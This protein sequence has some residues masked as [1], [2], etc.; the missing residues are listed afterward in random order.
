MEDGAETRDGLWLFAYGTL[1]QD[2]VQQALFGRL[3]R[4]E[5]D[6]LPGFTLEDVAIADA[7]VVALS[8]KGV[9]PILRRAG[10]PGAEV[11]GVALALTPAEL[12]AA[13]AYEVA[14]YARVAVTLRSGRAAF[15]YIDAT[16]A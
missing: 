9:H 16:Q 1:R 14:A 13:D 11:A 10:D 6:A 3:V 8:G 2:E 5:A 7:G 15:A 12:A 4:C